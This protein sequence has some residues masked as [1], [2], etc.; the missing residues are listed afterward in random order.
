M[1]RT[2]PPERPPGGACVRLGDTL[3]GKKLISEKDLHKALNAQL[4][5]GA[6]L[7]T[8][9]LELGY[10]DEDRLGETLSEMLGVPYATA[11]KLSDIPPHV[12]NTLPAAVAEQ[13]LAVPFRLA[14]RQLHIAMVDP[15]SIPTLDELAF[16]TGCRIQPWV[17]P[18]VRIFQALERYYDLARRQRYVTLARQLDQSHAKGSQTAVMTAVA[19]VGGRSAS[20]RA[21]HRDEEQPRAAAAPAEP[22]QAEWLSEA[23]D[24]LCR[25]DDIDRIGAVVLN[26]VGHVIP[27]CALFSVEGTTCT[28]W[29][30][31]GLSLAAGSFQVTDEL[32]FTLPAGDPVYLGPVP[33]E[34]EYLRF[35]QRHGLG[36][37]RHG[38]VVGPVHVKDRLTAVLYGDGGE[39]GRVEAAPQEIAQLLRKLSLAMGMILL[40]KQIR[41][42]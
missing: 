25:A 3:L 8:C 38:I 17:S 23:S 14:G 39:S 4:I 29:K 42:A 40:K 28:A 20:S 13:R 2:R 12:I 26:A 18:E 34:T 31:R 27:R 22:P 35:F 6:H 16:V 21:R 11:R 9:L 7:G 5:F 37:P 36:L 1:F 41:Q 32:L 19:G 24:Q 15:R 30:T 10:I 33:P